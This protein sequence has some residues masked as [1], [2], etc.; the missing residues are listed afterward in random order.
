MGI[1]RA[2]LGVTTTGATLLGP[3]YVRHGG[4]GPIYLS[5]QDRLDP[6]ALLFAQAGFSDIDIGPVRPKKR[7]SW[8]LGHAVFGDLVI[9][10]FLVTA[11]NPLVPGG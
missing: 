6:I 3:G 2:S 8:R 10:G 7:L 1:A 9:K 5:S 4:E 11:R